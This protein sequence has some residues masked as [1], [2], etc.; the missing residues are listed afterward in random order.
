M[1]V[2]QQDDKLVARNTPA[3][4]NN[5]REEE[6]S[7]RAERNAG[8]PRKQKGKQRGLNEWNGEEYVSY[9][10]TSRAIAQ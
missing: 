3:I 8:V 10:E 6:M 4:P 7:R 2:L 1:E 5:Q 9:R